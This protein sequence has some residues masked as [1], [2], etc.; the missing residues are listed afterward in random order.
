MG[1]GCKGVSRLVFERVFS[2]IF[3]ETQICVFQDS[4]N[5]GRNVY[6]LYVPKYLAT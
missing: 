6:T 4:G 2:L 5:L 1:F 3:V